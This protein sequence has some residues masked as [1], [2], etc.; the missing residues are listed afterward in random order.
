[1]VIAVLET[2]VLQ[3]QHFGRRLGGTTSRTGVVILVSL[4]I[5]AVSGLAGW[6]PM[7]LGRRHL[8]RAEF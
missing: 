7:R 2:L 4:V 8:E 6:L 3:W 5:L 1:V